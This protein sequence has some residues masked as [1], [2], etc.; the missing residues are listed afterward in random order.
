MLTEINAVEY[1]NG[2]DIHGR[3][4]NSLGSDKTHEMA[5]STRACVKS[6]E[7]GIV[8]CQDIGQQNSGVGMGAVL[9]G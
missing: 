1:A 5:L 9:P 8:H 6:G 2:N 7:D 4:D 3:E